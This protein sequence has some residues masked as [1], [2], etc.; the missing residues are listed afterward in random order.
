MR[1]KRTGG[2]GEGAKAVGCVRNKIGFLRAGEK[3]CGAETLME[4][5][6][7]GHVS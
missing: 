5:Q 6:E 3:E 4:R 1:A 2:G 7:N